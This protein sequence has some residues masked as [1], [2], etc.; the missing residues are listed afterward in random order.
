MN[1]SVVIPVLNE[2]KTIAASLRVLLP[3]VPHEIIVVDGG[4]EDRTRE[5]CGS[6]T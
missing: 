2:E 4:S 1:I 3:L 6:L 5:I